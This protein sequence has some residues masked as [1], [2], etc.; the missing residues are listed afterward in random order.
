MAVP[1]DVIRAFHNA[2]RKDL[3]AIDLAAYTA[4][5]GQAGL[6]IVQKRYIFFNQVLGWHAKGEEHFVFPA[7]EK[8]APSVAEAYARDHRGLDT[9]FDSVDEAVKASDLLAIA[10]ATSSFNFFSTFHL[11]KEEAHLYRIFNEKVA[12]SDQ[13]VIIGKMSQEPP[14]ERVPEVIDWL[15]HLIGADDRENMVRVFRQIMPEPVVTETLRL[16]KA[17]VGD[18]W[19]ELTRRIP[20]IK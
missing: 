5:R 11:N 13:W 10:R 4:A 15:F 12:L 18:G 7:L 20:E 14:R 2:F 3:Q 1:L 17:A 16:V 9:S 19:S 6:E 8:V